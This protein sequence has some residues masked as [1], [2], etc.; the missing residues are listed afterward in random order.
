[1][2]K[3]QLTATVRVRIGN[4]EKALQDLTAEERERMLAEMQA[5]LS[6]TMSRYY[7]QHAEERSKITIGQK[8]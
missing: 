5:R 1:M 8:Q 3:P 6:Q 7:A 4:T 2:A